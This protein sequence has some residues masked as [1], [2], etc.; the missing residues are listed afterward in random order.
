MDQGNFSLYDNLLMIL[1]IPTDKI[2]V[3][4]SSALISAYY[5]LNTVKYQ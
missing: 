2:Y 4:L 3:P 1:L 5:I